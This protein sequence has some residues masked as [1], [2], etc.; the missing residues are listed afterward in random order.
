M[1]QFTSRDVARLAGVSQST[2][3]YVMSGRRSVSQETKQRVLRAMRRLDYEPNAGARAL[4]GRRTHVIGLMAPSPSVSDPHGYGH[5]PFIESVAKFARSQDYEMLLVSADDG[6]AGLRRLAGRALCDGIIMMEIA[7]QD[8]RVRLAASL[9]ISVVLIG[10]PADPLGLSCVDADFEQAARLAI[11]ELA[12][13]DHDEVLIV[14]YP[15]DIVQRRVNF[16]ERFITSAQWN[17]RSRGLELSVLDPGA[18]SPDL[19]KGSVDRI[20]R[21]ASRARVGV[22]VPH[23][24]V[25]RMLVRELGRREAILGQDLSLITVGDDPLADEGDPQYTGISLRPWEVSQRAAEVL[26]ARLDDQDSESGPTVDLI[27]PQLERHGTVMPA[28]VVAP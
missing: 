12:D 27:A 6:S 2:V 5:M 4:A 3:S 20:L 23:H 22:V 18:P 21:R 24:R 16:V 11:G 25:K 13:S 7:T 17:A 10:V 26:F 28:P 9:P 15:T 8:E 1:S 14:N 19:V